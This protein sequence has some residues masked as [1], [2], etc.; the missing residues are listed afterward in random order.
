M[1]SNGRMLSSKSLDAQIS[2][3]L[4]LYVEISRYLCFFCPY[5]GSTHVRLTSRAK[6]I[7]M[8]LN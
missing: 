4:L 6:T 8:V 7:T 2:L 5:V 1:F 3:D